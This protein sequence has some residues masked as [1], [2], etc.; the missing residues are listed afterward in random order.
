[1]DEILTLKKK[2]QE[3]PNDIV[4]HFELA[5]LYYQ[6]KEYELAEEEF[7]KVFELEPTFKRLTVEYSK[8]DNISIIRPIGLMDGDSI[9]WEQFYAIICYL[10]E[11]GDKKIIIDCKNINSLNDL[12]LIMLDRKRKE[13][14]R[15]GGDIKL[16]NVGPI[17]KY[18]L[19]FLGYNKIFSIFE[20]EEEAVNAFK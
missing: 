13:I 9:Y 11:K 5:N 17:E 6:Q 7:K 2:I 10:I 19:E 12:G 15:F 4:S 14:K 16:I 1:M 3:N 18:T 8:V 20:T